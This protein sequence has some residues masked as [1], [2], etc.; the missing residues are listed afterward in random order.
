MYACF[1][2]VFTEFWWT[3][4]DLHRLRTADPPPTKSAKLS[5]ATQT[6]SWGKPKSFSRF[7]T[8]EV[9]PVML[10]EIRTFLLGN[11]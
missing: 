2:S 11:H 9:S 8:L 7:V 1:V 10:S 4:L 6:S 3:G 5:W